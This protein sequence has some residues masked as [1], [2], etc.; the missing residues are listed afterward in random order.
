MC[1]HTKINEKKTKTKLIKS[2]GGATHLLRSWRR[3]WFFT[4]LVLKVVCPHP[5]PPPD[6]DTAL[7]CCLCVCGLLPQDT[8]EEP[9]LKHGPRVHL[10]P[11]SS[12][13]DTSALQ[14]RSQRPGVGAPLQRERDLKA[15]APGMPQCQRGPGEVGAVREGLGKG[16]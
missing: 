7:Q 13:T 11:V 12:T 14:W 9:Q 1:S 8:L 3:N 15:G 10:L 4:W 5:T 6:A 2:V 16:V